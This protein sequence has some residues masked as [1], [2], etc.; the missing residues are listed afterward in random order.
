MFRVLGCVKCV[1]LLTRNN[2]KSYLFNS[3]LAT[4]PL[5]TNVR[6]F[7]RQ[8]GSPKSKLKS[9]VY[10][11]AALGVL[12]VGLSYAAVPLYRIFCQVFFVLCFRI[13]FY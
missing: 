1:E 9:T 6:F 2:C 10:Y 13:Y 11:V 4:R 8:S 7:S 5:E 3:N 12:T